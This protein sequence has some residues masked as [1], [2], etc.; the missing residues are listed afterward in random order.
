M[1]AILL[2]FVLGGAAVY[3]T[4]PQLGVAAMV[5]RIQGL[6]FGPIAPEELLGRCPLWGRR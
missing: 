2:A 6:H 4:Q 3:L 5:C 1:K